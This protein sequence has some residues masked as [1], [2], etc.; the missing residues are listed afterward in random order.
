MHALI[1]RGGQDRDWLTAG[2]LS[3]NP[4]RIPADYATASGSPRCAR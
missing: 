4:I 3:G 1:E 2:Q